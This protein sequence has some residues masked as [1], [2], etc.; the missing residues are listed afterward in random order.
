MTTSEMIMHELEYFNESIRDTLASK[1]INNTGEASKSLRIEVDK[2][3]YKSIGIFYLEFLNTGRGKDPQKSS[4]GKFLENIKKWLRSKH[5]IT[6]EE[7]LETTGKRVVYFINKLGTLIYRNNSLGIE[8]EKKT[9]V[10][11]E[12][13][14]SRIAETEAAEIRQVLDKYKKLYKLKT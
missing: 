1:R 2:D 9:K 4:S 8:L 14:L 7:E 3:I 6:D 11:K 5:G 10:L 12:A 13:I